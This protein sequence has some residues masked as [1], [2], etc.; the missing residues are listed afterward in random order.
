MLLAIDVG[1]TNIMFALVDGAVAGGAANAA[2]CA[3]RS[4]A[5][6]PEFLDFKRK[7]R[8]DGHTTS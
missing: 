7:R 5:E 6:S 3:R 4:G 8:G 1:N 2:D